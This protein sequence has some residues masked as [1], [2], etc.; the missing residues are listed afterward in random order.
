MGVQNGVVDLR[1]GTLRDGKPEDNITMST[2]VKFDPA[3]QC[4]LWRRTLQGIFEDDDELIDWLWRYCGYSITGLAKEQTIIMGHGEGG[5]G[6]G[7]VAG[8]LRKIMGDY[9]YDAPFSTFEMNYR[10]SIPNDIA[11]LEHKRIVTSSETNDGT[12]L[13]E[14]RLK[15]ISHG[16][17]V[18]ARYLHAEFFTYEPECKIFLFC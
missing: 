3:A 17:P 10:A 7:V 2:G 5:N 9:A 11:A 13:N 16:D 4:P 14:A 18:T 6:K 15:A 1:T 12:R 8:G